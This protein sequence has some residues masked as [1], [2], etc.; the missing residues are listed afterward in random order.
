MSASLS[1]LKRRLCCLLST[2]V[3]IA[4][5]NCISGART[6]LAFESGGKTMIHIRGP[7]SD[8]DICLMVPTD[9]KFSL[10]PDQSAVTFP[11]KIDEARRPVVG[12]LDPRTLQRRQ[13]KV[14]ISTYLHDSDWK[15]A[16]VRS[17][18]SKDFVALSGYST[19]LSNHLAFGTQV[20]LVSMT[21]PLSVAA[22]FSIDSL[23]AHDVRVD[24]IRDLTKFVN[25]IV[26][27][28]KGTRL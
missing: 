13:Q 7:Q 6:I 27:A 11:F 2:L 21:S 1:R 16:L 19:H 10:L 24:Q 12:V 9:A 17:Q 28:C 25:S 26:V 18:S 3:L 8:M 4:I 14:V 15:D 20:P 5:F 23:D 22:Y